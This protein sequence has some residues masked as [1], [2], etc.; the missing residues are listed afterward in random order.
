MAHGYGMAA[1]AQ[2]RA[3]TAFQRATSGA[4]GA[5]NSADWGRV[6]DSK[7]VVGPA[8]GG[9]AYPGA[10]STTSVADGGSSHIP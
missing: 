4:M 7:S 8:T 6:G 3:K 10:A 2:A 1:S 9:A 5:A